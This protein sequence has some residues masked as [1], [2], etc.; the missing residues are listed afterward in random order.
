MRGKLI[1]FSGPSGVG[2]GTI[3]DKMKFD[4]FSF[5][6][7]LTT[8]EKRDGE[9]DGVHYHF[10][11]TEYFQERIDSHKML[12]HAQFVGNYYGTDLD[13]V[14]K[15]LESGNN[16]FLEIE[17]QGAMQVLDK[18]DD[19]ISIF[20]VPPSIEELEA[21]LRNRGTEKA[22]TLLKRLE[23][24]REELELKDKYKYI[25]I[26]DLV[27]NAAAEVDQILKLEL[28]KN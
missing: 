24:A 26:N 28:E 8:R 10:V 12:E 4:N 9:V 6:V 23:K 20:I 21:R 18:I 1:V 17:C 25:V 2:K 15:Q 11:T 7:S 16:V 3:R 22:E 5:S 13:F 14:N 27:A 19:V